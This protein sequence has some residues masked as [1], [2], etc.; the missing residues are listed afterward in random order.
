VGVVEDAHR[1]GLMDERATMQVYVPLS[2]PTAER[3]RALFVRAAGDPEL[4]ANAVRRELQAVAPGLPLIDVASLAEMLDPQVRP[5]RTGAVMLSL[6]G[7][8]ALALAAIGI[9]AAVAYAV[10][11]R[12]HELGVRLA[13]GA[14]SRDAVWLVMRCGFVPAV[15]GAALGTGIT[16]AAGRYLEPLL[17]RVAARDPAVAAT[18]VLALLAAALFA[19]FLPGLRARRI[20]PVSAMRSE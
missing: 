9:F 17:F 8:L 19:S 6:F 5:W 3:S 12:T 18:A 2:P 16:L 11:A 20:D 4:L 15:A 1:G 13:L 7:A 10:A 14:R